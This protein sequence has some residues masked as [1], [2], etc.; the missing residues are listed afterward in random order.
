M[1]EILIFEII[2]KEALYYFQ[3]LNLN[4]RFESNKIEE[5]DSVKGFYY[6]TYT[7]IWNQIDS[8]LK[9]SF[10][11]V[12]YVDH[13][14]KEMINNM[15][16]LIQLNKYEGEVLHKYLNINDY[17]EKILKMPIKILNDYWGVSGDEKINTFFEW[18]FDN[19]DKKLIKILK[20]KDWIDIPFDWHEYK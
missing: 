17:F 8:N 5:R 16:I 18:F 7:Q 2:K 20:G 13:P 19:C 1:D 9:L 10:I 14:N 4:Y 3:R 12:F 6:K 15:T 11:F